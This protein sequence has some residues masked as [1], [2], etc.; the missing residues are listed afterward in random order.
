MTQTKNAVKLDVVVVASDS[1]KTP[2]PLRKPPS[3]YDTE[4]WKRETEAVLAMTRLQDEALN[5]HGGWWRPGKGG[6]AIREECAI[7]AWSIGCTRAQIV[8]AS[9][10]SPGAVDS[11]LTLAKYATVVPSL[12]LP[13]RA[14]VRNI[15]LTELAKGPATKQEICERNALKHIPTMDRVMLWMA[16][17]GEIA[18]AGEG[19][20]R[21]TR[22]GGRKPKI[23]ALVE[24]S[25]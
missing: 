17:S 14:L 11:A 9:G 16:R 1:H 12:D 22:N 24:K 25:T 13:H 4:E 5:P 6:P 19:H 18:I 8:K 10:G 20:R 2:P 15:V 23:W 21:S 7:D 3:I